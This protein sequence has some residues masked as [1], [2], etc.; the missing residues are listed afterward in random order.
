[1]WND[2][3]EK[4]IFNLKLSELNA[5]IAEERRLVR[6]TGNVDITK[7]TNETLYLYSEEDSDSINLKRSESIFKLKFDRKESSDGQIT[8]RYEV[9]ADVEYLDSFNLMD[10][11]HQHDLIQIIGYKERQSSPNEPCKFKA[12]YYRIIKRT[13]LQVYYQAI[14]IQYGHIASN[15][16]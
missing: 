6:I 4:T 3:N 12:L 10:M 11:H 7:S 15:I 5:L 1:M 2:E 14:D 9:I 16:K 8:Q 13:N